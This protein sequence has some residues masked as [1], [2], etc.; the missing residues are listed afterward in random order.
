MCVETFLLLVPHLVML[1]SGIYQEGKEYLQPISKT[2]K[3]VITMHRKYIFLTLAF[4]FH[5]LFAL[6]YLMSVVILIIR[7]SI[8]V[9][10]G[11]SD[12]DN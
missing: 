6:I 2:Y 12:E 11:T 4:H 8:A 9:L 3:V 7:N 5:Q 10:L 1:R